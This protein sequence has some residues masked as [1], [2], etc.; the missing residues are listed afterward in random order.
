[1]TIS[2]FDIQILWE[3]SDSI[4]P[5]HHINFFSIKGF[6]IIFEKCGFEDINIFTPGLLDVD[7]VK[8][9]LDKDSSATIDNRFLEKIVSDEELSA[10]FQNYLSENQLSSHAWIMAKKT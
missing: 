6:E 5:P 10:S 8:N 4:S 2:G 9:T 3:N 7:I 1:M